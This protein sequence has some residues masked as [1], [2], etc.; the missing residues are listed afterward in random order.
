MSSLVAIKNARDVVVGTGILVKADRVLTCAHVVNVALGRTSSEASKP[1]PN[2]A[3]SLAFSP[4]EGRS[5][6]V[7]DEDGAWSAPPASGIAGADVCLLRLREVAP[8]SAK[9]A[10]LR[11]LHFDKPF[12]ARVSGFP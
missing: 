2:V 8:T 7:A 5:A 6:V 4:A 10:K 3:V 1:G 9:I 12:E 11:V